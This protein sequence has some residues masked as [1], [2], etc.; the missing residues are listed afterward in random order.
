MKNTWNPIRRNRNIGTVKSGRSADNSLVVPER[1]AD[2]KI[3]WERL[4]NPVIN[5]FNFANQKITLLVEPPR[6]GSIHAST[7]QDV[8]RVLSLLPDEHLKEIEIV[9]FR[10]PSRKEEI[11]KPVWGRFVYYAD[12]G[13]FSGPGIYLESMATGTVLNWGNKI[14]PF[15]RRELETL[16]SE[17]HEITKVRRGYDIHTS[18]HAVRNTQLFRTLPH[19]IGHAVDY[20]NNSLMPSIEA[21]TE[22]ESDYIDAAF[23]SKPSLDKEEFANRYAREFYE[24]HSSSGHIPFDPIV[25]DEELLKMNLNPSWFK[26][27]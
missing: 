10:Q 16:Q 15:Q 22:T 1:W 27:K 7:P 5:Q 17:G 25:V 13:R 2:Y 12:L 9:V 23:R 21:P 3:F 26:V 18:P 8:R 20:L 14:T 4:T 24:R 19:E 6:E 11:L